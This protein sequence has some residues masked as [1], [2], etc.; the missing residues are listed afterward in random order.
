[1]DADI[2]VRTGLSAIFAAGAYYFGVFGII[3]WVLG[4]FSILDYTTGIASAIK[5][6]GLDSRIALWGAV[7]KICYVVLVV[8]AFGVDLI[9]GYVA[10]MMGWEMTFFPLGKL[11]IIYLISTEAISIL[12]NLAELGVEVPLLSRGVRAFR[13]KIDKEAK[14]GEKED[15]HTKTNH[16]E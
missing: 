4:I 14:K 16:P 10:G 2:P 8:V 3:L 6:R 9:I 7:R 1:M 12:E 11:S 15:G 13:D 5:K